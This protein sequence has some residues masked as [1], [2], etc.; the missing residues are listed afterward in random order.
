MPGNARQR[1]DRT[2]DHKQ[3]ASDHIAVYA[4]LIL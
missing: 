1:H 4:E 3:E 2:P